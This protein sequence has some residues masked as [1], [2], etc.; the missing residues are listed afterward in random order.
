MQ[1]WYP[2]ADERP[3]AWPVTEPKIGTP[4]VLIFHTMVGSL[5]GTES[6]FKRSG[7]DGTESHFGVGGPTDGDKL[8][9]AVWQ[10]TPLN[11]QADAQWDGN[12]YATSIETSD[13]GNPLRPWSTK[14]LKALVNLSLWWCRQ[15]D[16]DP[17]LV[18][19]PS[20]SG[21]GYHRQFKVWNDRGHSCPGDVRLSQLLRY[22]IPTVRDRYY[23][24]HVVRAGDTLTT[25]AAKWY[26]ASDADKWRAIYDANKRIIG[27]NPHVLAVGLRLHIPIEPK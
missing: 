20:E 22:V 19:A 4:R 8:D 25:I 9:G 14:Q 11:R 15:T 10:W 17:R 18:K 16:H 26:G 3:L 7:Y 13:G 5:K 21:F 27:T 2:G 1:L 6:L 24:V 12:A 23:N